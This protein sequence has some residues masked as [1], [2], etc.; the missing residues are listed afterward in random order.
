M[1][2]K[3]LLVEAKSDF[4]GGINNAASPDLLAPN[5]VT[6]IENARLGIFHGSLIKR[7][8]SQRMHT[9]AIGGGAAVPGVFQWDAPAGKELVAVSNGNFYHKTTALGEFTLVASTINTS[10]PISWMP[11]RSTSASAAL[12]LYF[13]DGSGEVWKW[14]GTTLTKITGGAGSVP[15]ALVLA[16][17]HTRVWALDERFLKH[18]FWSDVG[19]AEDW[20]SP[21]ITGGGSAIVDTLTGEDIVT[22]LTLGSSLAVA[23]GDSVSRITG[24]SNEDIVIAQ[25]NEGISAHHGT[26]NRDTFKRVE[27][28]A[29][30]HSDNGVYIVTES[31]AVPGSIKIEPELNQMLRHATA[32]GRLSIGYN[33]GR[34]EAMVSYWL[35][36]DAY[37]RNVAVLNVPLNA[38]SVFRYPFGIRQFARYEDPTTGAE[39]IV[40]GCE[41]GFVRHLDTGTKDDVLANDTGG[42]NVT[43]RVNLPTLFFATGPSSTKDLDRIMVQA[44]APETHNLKVRHFLDNAT[45]V[46]T[47][48]VGY[49]AANDD[50]TN[51]RV[52]LGGQFSRLRVEFHESSDQPV[53]VVGYVLYAW[54]MQRRIQHE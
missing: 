8:G 28:F 18:V 48:I 29:L 36:G 33:R 44:V 16:A 31:G 3:P 15:Q 49:S 12:V 41:D 4:R 47:S 7:S 24:Y 45:F 46:D 11:F 17:Y 50:T 52:D 21:G 34:R 1:P 22:L 42:S 37:Q 54:D 25:D 26:L 13:A 27:D 9:T 40:V 19:D 38:W 53:I 14:D 20:V 2:G 30:M 39:S 43:M 35:P 5:E 51:F 6:K 23:T 32:R 10:N